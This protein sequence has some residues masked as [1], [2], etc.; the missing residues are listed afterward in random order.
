MVN[1]MHCRKD[2]AP[3]HLFEEGKKRTVVCLDCGAG[4]D[5]EQVQKYGAGLISEMFSPEQIEQLCRKVAV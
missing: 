3:L 2:G 4:N 5:F 1:N